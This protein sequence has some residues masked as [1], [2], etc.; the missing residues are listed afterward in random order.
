MHLKID[1]SESPR[2]YQLTVTDNGIGIDMEAASGKLFQM[3][4]RFNTTHPGQGF[5]LYLV[6]SQMEAIN[7]QVEIDSVLGQGTTFKLYFNKK[8]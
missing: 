3:Y 7:G 4:Q 8:Q 2:Y 5:G 1:F 6:K